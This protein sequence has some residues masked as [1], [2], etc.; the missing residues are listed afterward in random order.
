MRCP[1]HV[2]GLCGSCASRQQAVEHLVSRLD[3]DARARHSDVLATVE[4]AGPRQAG[5]RAALPF[6]LHRYERVGLVAAVCVTLALLPQVLP[7]WALLLA[8]LT[9]VASL[10]RTRGHALDALLRGV[11]GFVTGR[12]VSDVVPR[13][14]LGRLHGGDVLHRAPPA[15]PPGVPVAEAQQHLRVAHAAA[16]AAR[17]RAQD[18]DLQHLRQWLDGQPVR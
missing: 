9:A 13:P 8:L 2:S 1:H 6:G 16:H 5:A 14:P 18:R 10:I 3:H 12:P 17:T 4:E 11:R 7:P 15:A